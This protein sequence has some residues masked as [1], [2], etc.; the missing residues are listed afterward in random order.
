[1]LAQIA[2]MSAAI[3]HL[4]TALFMLSRLLARL[5]FGRV[6]LL[7]Y[8]INAQPVPAGALTP[9]QRGQSI[10]VTEGTPAQARSAPF[11]RPEAA[12]EHRLANGARHVVARKDGRLIGVQWFTLRDYPEDEVRCVF[13]LRVFPLHAGDGC[14]WG[15]DIFVTPE[16]RTMPVLTQLCNM[17]NAIFRSAGIEFTMN[18]INACDQAS[19]HAHARLRA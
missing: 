18:R 14:A 2:R 3:G 6:K 15:F 8:Y 12:I 1:M 4:D 5:A 9:T 13:P 19:M 17:V 16:A 10:V 7:K 11:G